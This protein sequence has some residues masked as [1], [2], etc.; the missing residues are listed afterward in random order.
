LFILAGLALGSE[1]FALGLL[2]LGGVLAAAASFCLAKQWAPGIWPAV[3]ALAFLL[4]PIVFW[5]ITSSRAPDLWMA[6][7][8]ALGVPLI[9]RGDRNAPASIALVAGICAGAVAGGKYTG[10]LLAGTMA[11]ALVAQTKSLLRIILFFR[12]ALAAGIWPYARNWVWSGDPLFPFGGRIFHHLQENS[13]ALASMRA[14]TGAAGKHLGW[15]LAAMPFCAA[16]DSAHPQ[17]SGRFSVRF[18]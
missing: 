8:A 13:F 14:D 12:G 10:I 16:F 4:T 9:A 3:A 11:I 1:K 15:H 5:Q 17:A 6:F 18:A 2:F 7:F